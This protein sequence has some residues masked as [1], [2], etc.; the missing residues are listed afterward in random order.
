MHINERRAFLRRALISGNP[1]LEDAINNNPYFAVA[2]DNFCHL[3]PSMV[4][5]IYDDAK[6]SYE[7]YKILTDHISK[8]VI[9]PVLISEI[10]SEAK[11]DGRNPTCVERWPECENGEYH[12]SCCKYPKSCSC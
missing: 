8:S 5:G 11:P 12:P 4:K 10:I 2:F 1:E 3:L 9:N 7:N 6:L